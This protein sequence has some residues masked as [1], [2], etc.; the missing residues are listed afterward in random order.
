ML[1]S[2]NSMKT[3]HTRN[4]TNFEYAF[5]NLL[6]KEGVFADINQ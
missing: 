4:M 6:L 2:D 3:L 1:K 5:T